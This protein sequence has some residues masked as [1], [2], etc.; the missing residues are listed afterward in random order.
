MTDDGAVDLRPLLHAAELGF[1]HPAHA[2]DMRF[3]RPLPPDF[4]AWLDHLR[5]VPSPSRRRG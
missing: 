5:A 1:V 3:E 4:A 2:R